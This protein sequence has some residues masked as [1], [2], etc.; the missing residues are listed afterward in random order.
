MSDNIIGQYQLLQCTLQ[1]ISRGKMID[2]G[3][4]FENFIIFESVDEGFVHGSMI[5]IDNN[6]IV[7]EFPINGEE[8]LTI[9]TKDWFGVQ[10]TDEF[11]VYGVIHNKIDSS[12]SDS[13]Q[14]Y[15][16]EFCSVPRFLAA[17]QLV[18]RAYKQS[19]TTMAEDVFR[20][21]YTNIDTISSKPKE[22]IV[23]PKLNI[24]NI[25][26]PSY[27]FIE[28]MKMLARFA[29][30]ADKN[31]TFRFFETREKFFFGD[32]SYFIEEQIQT[33][34]KDGKT[35]KDKT[36]YIFG[37]NDQSY[38]N[39]DKKMYQI[40]SI[41]YGKRVD[42]LD[43]IQKGHYKRR[44]IELDIITREVTSKE[45]SYPRDHTSYFNSDDKFLNHNQEFVDNVIAEPYDTYVVK[46]WSDQHNIMRLNPNFAELYGSKAMSTINDK[47]NEIE[48]EIYGRNTLRP[49]SV[50]IL[51]L[52]KFKLKN[53]SAIELDE[54]RFGFYFVK[55]VV[56]VF[57]DNTFTQSII[58]TRSGSRVE[59]TRKGFPII[60]RVTPDERMS[61]TPVYG[62]GGDGVLPQNNQ[63]ANGRAGAISG[64]SA[65]GKVT[66]E[67]A[68]RLASEAGFSPEE[69]KVM[70]AIAMAESSGNPEA[71][72]GT[73]AD[74]SY[75]LWQMN[76]KYSGPEVA[77]RMNSWGITDK[78]QLYAPPANAQ[79]AY[80]LYQE[81]G[82]NAWSTY[83]NGDYQKYLNY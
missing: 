82:F 83:N 81:Q 41:D 23:Q 53:G 64:N 29:F 8:K 50:I 35:N 30:T 12:K 80:R 26:I 69:A 65:G 51:D 39:L 1:S 46:D 42:T 63:D 43:D 5:I 61:N 13:T 58:V 31:S 48:L 25:V 20:A 6:N 79:A 40:L 57:K 49:G 74:D 9:V 3:T 77:R 4:L 45:K 56:N 71:Y 73:G 14:S 7:Q 75:G 68:E 34:Y 52:P 11:Y 17:T 24:A 27:N 70:A 33:E 22:I 54:E 28:A 37:D 62:A 15:T 59:N 78:S 2:I 19:I 76:L 36:F 60:T 10:K 18:R 16:L 21:Y 72:N 66:F 55:S 67:E 32:L 38:E 44:I 47:D